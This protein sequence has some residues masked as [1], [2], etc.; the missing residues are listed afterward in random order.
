MVI[1]HILKLT[2]LADSQ[3]QLLIGVL[4]LNRQKLI[5]LLF[6]LVFIFVL[7]ALSLFFSYLLNP[8]PIQALFF[9]V[10]LAFVL[11]VVIPLP[12]MSVLRL[13]NLVIVAIAARSATSGV[14]VRARLRG[15]LSLNARTIYLATGIL[16]SR[17]G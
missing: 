2:H 17:L 15:A 11:G 7:L 6:W 14:L 5:I 12:G 8:D 1:E 4:L 13:S 10:V 16:C 9:F 3:Q